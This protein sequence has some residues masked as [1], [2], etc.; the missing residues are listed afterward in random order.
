MGLKTWFMALNAYSDISEKEFMDR[1]TW[2]KTTGLQITSSCQGSI[3]DAPNPPATLDWGTK[4]TA[5]KE[6]GTCG[7]DWAIVAASAVE[8]LYALKVGTLPILSVQQLLE[9]SGDY[10]N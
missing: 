6:Q 7:Q 5:V 8:S 2:K 1:Y 4:V 10:G 3:M 9:C